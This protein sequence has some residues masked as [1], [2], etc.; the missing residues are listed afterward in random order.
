MRAN[1]FR[2]QVGGDWAMEIETFLSPVKWHGA[3]KVETQNFLERIRFQSLEF[4]WIF[5]HKVSLGW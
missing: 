1:P 5:Y 2:G 3:K 4:L